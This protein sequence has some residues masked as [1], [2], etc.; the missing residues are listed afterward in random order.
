M[1][2]EKKAL[3]FRKNGAVFDKLNKNV[4]QL[5]LTGQNN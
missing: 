4:I 5:R 2:N 3:S 1:F